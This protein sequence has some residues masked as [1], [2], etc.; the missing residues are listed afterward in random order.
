[1]IVTY[2]IGGRV[3]AIEFDAVMR[4][5][6]TSSSTVTSHPVER[7]VNV[8]DHV[9]KNADALTFDAIVTNTP[10]RVPS[11]HMGGAVG[12]TSSVD[13]SYDAMSGGNVTTRKTSASVLSFSAP[14]DRIRNVYDEIKNIENNGLTVSVKTTDRI[15]FRDYENM[16][17][18]NVS[19]P[20]DVGDGSSRTFSFQLQ[21]LRIVD[22]RKVKAPSAKKTTKHKGEKG[23]KEITEDK[24]AQL[25]TIAARILDGVKSFGKGF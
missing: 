21:E 6:D 15:G 16:T 11:T 2:E 8:N 20:T 18:L 1:M 13:V 3:V 23:K 10:L 19:V 4:M 5:N 14:F 17:I 22:T 25:K 24:D 12:Q 7:G 9:R